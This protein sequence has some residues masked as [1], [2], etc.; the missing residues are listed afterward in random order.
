MKIGVSDQS[1]FPAV[2]YLQE[3]LRN[4]ISS[5]VEVTTDKSQVDVYFQLK[6]TVGKP[7]SYKLESTPEY[8]RVE[9]MMIGYY[10][11]ITTIRQLLPATIEV[12]GEKQNLFY[13]CRANRRCA[14]V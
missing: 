1:L 2:G 9:A 13:P 6:D 7:G 14:T 5:S 8:I 12:Q 10:F 11:A 3:I 4:V